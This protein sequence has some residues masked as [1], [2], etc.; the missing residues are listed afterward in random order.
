M[1]ELETV[2]TGPRQ[3]PFHSYPSTLDLGA[4]CASLRSRRAGNIIPFS[5]FFITET[6]CPPLALDTVGGPNNETAID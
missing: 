2:V 3:A 4:S 5:S 1:P 6:C